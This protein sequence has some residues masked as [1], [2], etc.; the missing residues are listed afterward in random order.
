MEKKEEDLEVLPSFKE[1]RFARWLRRVVYPVVAGTLLR[2]LLSFSVSS[3]LMCWGFCVA[4]A[5]TS[6]GN[7]PAIMAG[8]VMMLGS[9]I[10]LFLQIASVA[11]V[12]RREDAELAALVVSAVCSQVSVL[13]PS[14]TD[15]VDTEG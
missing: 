5:G 9:A 1:G 7:F 8:A 11:A 14:S 12:V 13:D 6:A 2:T 10:G 3:I 15:E 4:S